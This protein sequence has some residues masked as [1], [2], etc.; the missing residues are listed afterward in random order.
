MKI[1]ADKVDIATFGSAQVGVVL[2]GG[3]AGYANYGDILLLLSIYEL[4]ASELPDAKIATIIEGEARDSWRD[5]LP[6]H[7][8]DSIIPFYNINDVLEPHTSG[9]IEGLSDQFVFPP[10]VI[11]HYYGGG[12]INE[13]WGSRK[14]HS[15]E[16]LLTG[17]ENT[18]IKTSIYFTGVQ[19]SE[20]PEA[21]RW[22]RLLSSAEVIGVRDSVSLNVCSRVLGAA[23]AGKATL[24]GDDALPAIATMIQESPPS[25]NPSIGIHIN[26][27]YYSTSVKLER[28]NAL[29]LV[30]E[31]LHGH[32]GQDAELVHRDE[33]FHAGEGAYRE[34]LGMGE[35]D[36][37][38]DAVDQRVAQGD[39]RVHAA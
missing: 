4:Y 27:A 28:F 24:Q 13:A 30:L 17:C 11:F 15:G 39:K 38:Q 33:E 21:Y 29:A 1:L 18:G 16:F 36:H 6:R 3:F 35:V 2:I 22:R 5:K 19:V 7:V 37:Q 12:Y 31:F 10:R 8:S 32:F 26:T 14:R 34:D 23:S 20:G 25:L 9:E